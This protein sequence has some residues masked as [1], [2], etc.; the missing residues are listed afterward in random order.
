ML[1]MIM[2]GCMKG[3]YLLLGNVGLI[4]MVYAI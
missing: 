2:S 3:M 1:I 4:K